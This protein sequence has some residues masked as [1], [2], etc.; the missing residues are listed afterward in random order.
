MPPE[1]SGGTLLAANAVAWPQ[2]SEGET[3]RRVDLAYP[4][5]MATN[6]HSDLFVRFFASE[7][8]S[9]RNLRTFPSTFRGDDNWDR[10]VQK[11]RL[12]LEEI[13]AQILTS[14]GGALP[15]TLLERPTSACQVADRPMM[16]S[17]AEEELG[18]RPRVG[19]PPRDRDRDREREI[20]V[21]GY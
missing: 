18:E 10:F 8:R 11:R 2:A 13:T 4:D 17:S 16:D 12:N 9:T 21:T 3:A 7:S 6:L 1:S 15:R 19:R 20:S 5:G 14:T